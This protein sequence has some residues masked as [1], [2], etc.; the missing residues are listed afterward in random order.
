M[1]SEWLKLC[2]FRAT[3]NKRVL[4]NFEGSVF[5]LISWLRVIVRHR[6]SNSGLRVEVRHKE[7]TA[8]VGEGFLNILPSS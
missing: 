3:S 6:T 2:D 1:P 5:A 8:F 7:P 4:N